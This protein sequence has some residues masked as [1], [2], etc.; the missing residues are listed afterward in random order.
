LRAVLFDMD[1]TLVETEHYWDQSLAGLAERLG[2]R[3]SAAARTA[4]VGTNMATSLDLMTADLGLVRSRAERDADAAWVIDA[5][6]GLMAQGVSWRPGARELLAEVRAAGLATALVTTTPR[7]LASL[8]LQ[9]I[10]K[11]PN[12]DAAF[13]VTVCG[14][15]VAATKPDPA[16]YRQ[17]M[18]ALGVAPQECVVI[19]DSVS[20]VTAALAAGAAVLAVP[21][22][23]PLQPAPALTVR[24]TLA[25]VA[26]ADLTGVL[27]GRKSADLRS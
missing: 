4:M 1:G 18:T 9:H 26:L 21:S 11:L 14:D 19:E 13:D 20:G 25:G 12:G 15:E 23:Q 10:G 17:A 24:D 6:A 16:P 27:G 3:L 7:R 22:L 5:T 8:V 2:G